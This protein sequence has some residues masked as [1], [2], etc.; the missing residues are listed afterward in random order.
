MVRPPAARPG[1]ELPDHFGFDRVSDE[2]AAP[3]NGPVGI[4]HVYGMQPVAVGRGADVPAAAGQFGQHHPRPRPADTALTSPGGRLSET[5][6]GRIALRALAITSASGAVS[7][8]RQRSQTYGGW[9]ASPR[10]GAATDA[11]HFAG[12]CRVG[13]R[14]GARDVAHSLAR[15]RFWPAIVPH[16]AVLP[17]RSLSGSSG[18]GGNA[19]PIAAASSAALLRVGLGR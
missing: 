18:S 6:N 1:K 8:C 2:S 15:V 14:R 5:V 9:S 11:R 13:Q 19:T 4:D 12:C 16:H 17:V 3:S 10:L 7:A